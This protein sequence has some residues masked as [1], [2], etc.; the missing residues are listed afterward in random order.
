MGR[1]REC[2]CMNMCLHTFTAVYFSFSRRRLKTSSTPIPAQHQGVH[3]SSL[4]CLSCV[5]STL[6]RRGQSW[7]SLSL[8]FRFPLCVAHLL[9][10]CPL[11]HEHAI[12]PPSWL[13]DPVL[14]HLPSTA[15]SLPFLQY[16]PSPTEPH[17]PLPLTPSWLLP[18]LVVREGRG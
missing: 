14:G 11:L 7:L 10:R 6:L 4:L 9:S 16:S 5:G 1:T 8:T 12:P 13:W 17:V 18:V 3:S 2:V 15:L